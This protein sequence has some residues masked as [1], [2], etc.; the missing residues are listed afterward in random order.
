MD[1]FVPCK[2]FSGPIYTKTGDDELWV[3]LL[4]KAYAKIYG[5]YERLISGSPYHSLPD[6]TGCPS[7]MFELNDVMYN[8]ILISMFFVC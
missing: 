7:Q 2:A 8:I 5:C 6:L 3:A 1:D 4:E